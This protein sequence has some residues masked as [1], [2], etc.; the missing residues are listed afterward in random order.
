MSVSFN[1]QAGVYS[2]LCEFTTRKEVFCDL[3]PELCWNYLLSSC[4]S[5]DCKDLWASFVCL[6]SFCQ[7]KVILSVKTFFPSIFFFNF[8]DGRIVV[9]E[10]KKDFFLCSSLFFTLI[11][12]VNIFGGQ[13]LHDFF[14]EKFVSQIAKSSSKSTLKHLRTLL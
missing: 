9:E 4:T 6:I 8:R 12:K 11:M 3:S 14:A 10:K 13:Y 2:I 7:S 1:N 5:S